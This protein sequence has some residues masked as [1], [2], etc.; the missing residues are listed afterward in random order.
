LL[1]HKII[2]SGNIKVI[3]FGAD[4]QKFQPGNQLQARKFLNL[5]TKNLIVTIAGR[6]DPVKDQLTFLTSANIISQKNKSIIFLI[7]GSRL[8]RFFRPE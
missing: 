3:A 7:V 6:L 4:T 1:N 2:K 8:G 5:P